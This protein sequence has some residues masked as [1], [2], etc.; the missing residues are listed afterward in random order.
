MR[1]HKSFCIF[2]G[3][4]AVTAFHAQPSRRW[5]RPVEVEVDDD[6]SLLQT[7]LGNMHKQHPEPGAPCTDCPN[8]VFMITDDQDLT[9]GGWDPMVQTRELIQARGATASQWRIHTPYCAPSRSQLMSGRYFR[10]V[11]SSLPTPSE[12]LVSGGIQH[13]DFGGQAWPYAFPRTLRNERGYTTALFGKCM[14]GEGGCGRNDG[15]GFNTDPDGGGLHLTGAFDRWFELD[16][17]TGLER[18]ERP[19]G[20]VVDGFTNGDFFD[21]RAPGCAWPWDTRSEACRADT[22]GPEWHGRGDGDNTAALG[23]VTVEWIREVAGQGRPFL[24][25]YAAF[26]PHTPAIPAPWYQTGT[27]CD[28]IIAPRHPNFDYAGEV[29]VGEFCSPMPPSGRASE[30]RG[31][32][33]WW[34]GSDFHHHI[35]CQAPLTPVD[36]AELDDLAQNRCKTLLS[37]DDTYAAI[38]TALEE[39]GVLDNTYIF[40]TSDHGY[41]L[42][43]HRVP[44]EKNLLYDHSLRIPMLFMGPGITAGS[45]LELQGTNVDLAPTILGLAGIETPAYMDGRSVVPVLVNG[46]AEGVPASVRRHLAWAEDSGAAA[47]IGSRTSSFFTHFNQGPFARFDD[48]SNTAIG[49]TSHCAEGNDECQGP[50]GHWKFAAYDP[51]GKQTGFAQPYMYEL[52]DL[53]AD[54]YELHNLYNATQEER[55][56]VVEML[57][58]LLYQW[59]NCAGSDCL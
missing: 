49:L 9:L 16:W 6:A 1:F 33:W 30:D 10:H 18:G 34:G 7:S 51:Y 31:P 27:M 47:A 8:I 19:D 52:F 58:T 5:Q 11:Q 17:R 42:G 45:T 59:Y 36:I 40:V 2:A 37:V 54:P 32:V 41:N 14:N 50:V 22:G 20:T 3:V 39:T 13:V 21:N 4:H 12:I 23:N 46:D 38:V 35:S 57:H 25:Y 55:P 56:E 43:H 24:A 28:D 29:N 44:R 26:A 48:W 53:D 15:N